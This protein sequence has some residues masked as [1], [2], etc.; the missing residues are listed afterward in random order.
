MIQEKEFDAYFFLHT[1][2][3]SKQVNLKMFLKKQETGQ[4][5]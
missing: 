3:S 5:K 2:K 4:V 1:F